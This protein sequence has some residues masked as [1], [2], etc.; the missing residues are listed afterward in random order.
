MGTVSE[1]D[2]IVRFLVEAR[3]RACSSA[4]RITMDVSL[5]RHGMVHK[6]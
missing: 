6:R 1:P 2:A 3:N 5:I 4:V